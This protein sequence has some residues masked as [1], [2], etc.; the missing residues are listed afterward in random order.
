MYNPYISWCRQ[1]FPNATPVVDSFHVIQWIIRKLENYIRDL[2]KKYRKRDRDIYISN[3]GQID[4]HTRIPLSREVYLLQ[5]YRWIILANQNSIT[6]H[7][8]LRMDPH[9]HC[10]MNTFDYE[11]SLF[12]LIHNYE[13]FVILKNSMSNLTRGMLENPWMPGSNWIS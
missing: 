6:Y 8:D 4:E 7:S 13:N 1:Y 11:D 10:M 12:S 5:K 3:G 2:I 9:L